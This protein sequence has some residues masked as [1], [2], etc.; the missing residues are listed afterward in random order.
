MPIWLLG[1]LKSRFTWYGIGAV[2]LVVV[3]LGYRSHLIN[4]GKQQGKD[5]QK[6]SDQ[7]TID[8]ERQVAKAEADRKVAALTASAAED[9]KRADQ[10][11][12]DAA[13]YA[14]RAQALVSQLANSRQQVSAIPQDQLHAQA[15]AEVQRSPM[16]GQSSDL[17]RAV[18][19]RVYAAPILAATNTELSG[20]VKQLTTAVSGLKD[21][22]DKLEQRDQVRVEYEAKLE[23]YYVRLY[24]LHP[25]RKR[26]PRCLYLWRCADNKLPVPG[27][28]EIKKEK[29]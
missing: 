15:L 6:Q 9:R 23:G 16:A 20:Q 11:T 3:L 19:E 21:Q 4:Q 8:S 18:V 24:N 27:L 5:E 25:P 7:Q 13:V 29:P 28:E 10:A 2:V 14:A 26:A 22:V 17:E 12:A 1:A